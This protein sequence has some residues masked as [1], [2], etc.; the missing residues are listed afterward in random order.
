MLAAL[1]IES[2]VC[3]FVCSFLAGALISMGLLKEISV[4]GSFGCTVC[5]SSESICMYI[6]IV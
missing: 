1:I 3:F 4:I 5:L 2:I 6:P